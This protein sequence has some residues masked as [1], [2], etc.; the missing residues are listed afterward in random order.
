MAN[1][2]DIVIQREARDSR[3]SLCIS[4]PINYSNVPLFAASI[5]SALAYM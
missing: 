3:A 2:N 5:I 1:N 4:E